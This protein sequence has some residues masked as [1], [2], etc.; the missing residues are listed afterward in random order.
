M[1][2]HIERTVRDSRSARPRDELVTIVSSHSQLRPDE[3]CSSNTLVGVTNKNL[4][5][6]SMF[7]LDLVSYTSAKGK[8]RWKL[9]QPGPEAVRLRNGFV[10]ARASL[11]LDRFPVDPDK[12]YKE[13][14]LEFMRRYVGYLNNDIF[15]VK[16]IG[17]NGDVISSSG[18]CYGRSQ[19]RELAR[20]F[21]E[22]VAWFH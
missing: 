6:G 12:L 21:G 7:M 18:E 16:H 22:D 13:H 15:V 11:V 9:L 4:A 10:Y 19:A 5:S 14:I 20:S 2:V 3:C 1:V 17:G 8:I